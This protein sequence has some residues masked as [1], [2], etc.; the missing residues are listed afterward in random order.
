MW[1]YGS[2]IKLNRLI[3]SPLREDT[4][5]YDSSGRKLILSAYKC[6]S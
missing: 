5:K 4:G 2:R 1:K 6:F 3:P